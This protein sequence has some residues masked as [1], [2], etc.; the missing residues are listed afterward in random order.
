VPRSST[1]VP[2]LHSPPP[3]IWLHGIVFNY[4]IRCRDKLNLPQSRSARGHKL[5]Y[6]CFCRESN[7]H[8][9]IH[10]TE[11]SWFYCLGWDE[12]ESTCYAGHWWV[13]FTSPGWCCT[14]VWSIRWNETWQSK[15]KYS[16]KTCPSAT[17]S[18]IN[19][20]WSDLVSNPGCWGGK[21][22]TNPTTNRLSGGGTVL[23]LPNKFV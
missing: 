1:I 6:R 22:T 7:P 17:C 23:I 2:Y 14:W 11:L 3:P 12:T 20:T 10:F 5:K 18:T 21:P 19:P 13:H 4:I 15:P 9:I 8:I 16:E